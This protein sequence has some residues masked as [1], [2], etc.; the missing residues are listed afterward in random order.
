MKA[1]L[2]GRVHGDFD[3]IDTTNFPQKRKE[4]GVELRSSI[5]IEQI[6]EN[7]SGT[8]I[9]E[10]TAA[11]QV[12]NKVESP[13]I[14]D[15]G[16]IIE[17]EPQ[18]ETSTISTE[19]ASVP[20]EF[21]VVESSKHEFAFDMIGRE[22]GASI[23]PI[24]FDLG[25]LADD[26]KKDADFWMSGFYEHEGNASKGVTYGDDV[27]SD[28]EIGEAVWDSEKNQLGMDFEFNSDQVRMRITES[29][30]VQVFQPSEYETLSFVRLIRDLLLVYE[31]EMEVNE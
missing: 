27:F 17:N 28:P 11:E 25:S 21:V 23:E 26:Y 22:V 10:G 2:V 9:I 15:K 5:N 6:T 16:K 18:L 1:G 8:P 30:Y 12:R 4:K 14:D 3:R 13:S 31:Y 29:G 19:F 24:Q 20:G 7:V